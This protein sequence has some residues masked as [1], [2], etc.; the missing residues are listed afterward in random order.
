M[1]DAKGKLVGP[2]MQRRSWNMFVGA[3][4]R[5]SI[6]Y[7]LKV[8]DRYAGL[9]LDAEV[10]LLNYFVENFLLY[11][12]YYSKTRVKVHVYHITKGETTSHRRR[13][14]RHPSGRRK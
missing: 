13:G 5:V 11:Y 9:L 6:K 4:Q 12:S 3:P 1:T 7:L 8:D 14:C 2:H 10:T